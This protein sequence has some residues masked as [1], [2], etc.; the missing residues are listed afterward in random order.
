MGVFPAILI[1][2]RLLN[3]VRRPYFVKGTAIGCGLT[4]IIV[5]VAFIL[6]FSYAADNKRKD[7]E[8]GD[9]PQDEGP[10]DV[11]AVGDKHNH[12]RLLT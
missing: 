12:F 2:C 9:V 1:S 5:P 10:I 4:G 11:S 8:F 7:R 3:P 6:H